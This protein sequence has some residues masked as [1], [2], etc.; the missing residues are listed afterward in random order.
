MEPKRMRIAHISDFHTR[1]R[2][3]GHPQIL[4][5][6]ARLLPDLL[7]RAVAEI[8]SHDPDVLA[9]TGDLV[10]APFYGMD[11]PQMIDT[12]RQDLQMLRDILDSVG[13]PILICH[14]NHDQPDAFRDVFLDAPRDLRIGDHRFVTFFDDE[15]RDNQAE[16]L[17]EQ[18]DRFEQVLNDNDPTPQIH[19]QHYMV[20]PERNEGYPHS[21]RESVDLQDRTASSGKVLLSL[22]GHYHSGQDVT[23]HGDTWY[24]TA[25]AFCQPPHPY[26][27]YE[28]DGNTVR[29]NE[30][31]VTAPTMGS[32]LLIDLGLLMR[33]SERIIPAL[34]DRPVVAIAPT[35]SSSAFE[36]E[37][38]AAEAHLRDI[39]IELASILYRQA[40]DEDRTTLYNRAG[41]V[42]G[43]DLGTSILIST[44]DAEV[45]AARKAGLDAR[46]V[47]WDS[48]GQTLE[49]LT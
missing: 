20:W 10:D 22:S 47:S 2:V 48:I 49:T 33:T 9:V 18:R 3:P 8:R 26:R 25:R 13:C 4:E 30:Y 37:T 11:D 31:A 41:T 1:R 45:E 29:Q 36:S 21:Y 35:T 5:R 16:R 17:G 40:T 28:V 46:I 34:R 32:A 44:D 24:A 39:G 12:V 38:D 7:A 14:G 23:R 43:M 6:R 42:L 27:I 15:V 19:I